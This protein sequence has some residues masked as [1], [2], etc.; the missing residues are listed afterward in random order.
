MHEGL[1]AIIF[2]FDYTLVDSSTA[3]VDCINHGLRGTGH[4]PVPAELACK[5]IGLS[6]PEA[7]T[8]L[9]AA[10]AALRSA[11]FVRLFH[12]RADEIMVEWTQLF[13]A[14]GT[15]IRRLKERGLRLGIVSNKLRFRIEAILKLHRLYDDFD[16]IIGAEDFSKHKPDP[17]GIFT[18]LERMQV[19]VARALYI[20]DSTTDAEAAQRAGMGFVAVLSG[21]TPAEA[22]SEYPAVAVLQDLNGLIAVIEQASGSTVQ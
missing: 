12:A 22:F 20:G 15:V 13:P 7:Y 6:L 9:V 11:E 1:D 17:E 21:V 16:S 3:I 14:A 4:A 10:D 8:R 5:T 19:P 18:A 2:D